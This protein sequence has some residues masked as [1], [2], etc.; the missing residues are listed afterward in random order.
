MYIFDNMECMFGC[1]GKILPEASAAILDASSSLHLKNRC[2]GVYHYLCATVSNFT[3]ENQGIIQH[4]VHYLHDIF[5]FV[6]HPHLLFLPN[7]PD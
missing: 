7:G 6:K 5:A 2:K 4:K 1:A 3:Y